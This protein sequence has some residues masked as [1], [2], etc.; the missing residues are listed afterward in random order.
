MNEELQ[1]ANEEMETTNEELR[2]R[3]LELNDANAF[4]ETVLQS[5]GV[6][7]AVVDREQVIQLW[8]DH[9]EDLWGVRA[10]EAVG[11]HILS[12]DIG[13]PLERLAPV[14][15]GALASPDGPADLAVDATD[16]RGRP[17][18]CRLTVVPLAVDGG[19]ITTAVVLM[20]RVDP[21]PG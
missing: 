13:L 11:A 14:L 21:K 5:M 15:R 10:D 19:E 8:N 2:Q 3:S 9:A 18:A 4:M 1:S 7:V 12:L 17:F 20:R 6:G 16:R